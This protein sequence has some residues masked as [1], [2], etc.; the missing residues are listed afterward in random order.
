MII[1]LNLNNPNLF[2]I[3]YAKTHLFFLII[4]PLNSF[5]QE[6]DS[7]LI[8]IKEDIKNSTN[9]LLKI[10]NYLELNKYYHF[11]DL[12]KAESLLRE[13]LKC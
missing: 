9:D 5:S 6:I 3:T 11:R 7:T 12:D 4:F 8:K 10:V 2:S 1:R 13:I